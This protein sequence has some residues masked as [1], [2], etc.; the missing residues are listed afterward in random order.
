MATPQSVTDYD[1]VETLEDFAVYLKLLADD[2]DQDVARAAE[3]A[4]SGT[5]V[6]FEGEWAYHKLSDF[7]GQWGHWLH[8]AVLQPGARWPR[9]TVDPLDW[10]KLAGQL[11]AARIYE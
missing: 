5:N 9:E 11:F 10:N 1:A 7:L 3:H 8:S 4:A 6:P 2:F